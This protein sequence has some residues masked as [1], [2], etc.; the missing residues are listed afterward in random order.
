MHSSTTAYIALQNLYKDQHKS[1][2]AKFRTI[3]ASVLDEVGLPADAIPDD[4]LEGFVKNSSAVAIIK[5]TPLRESK[6]GGARLKEA[7]G[8]QNPLGVLMAR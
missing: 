3:L 6:E 4:E 2:L 7:I 1:D 8:K 5:G